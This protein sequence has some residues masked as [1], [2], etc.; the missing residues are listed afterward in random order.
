MNFEDIEMDGVESR[1]VRSTV[2]NLI[3][4]IGLIYQ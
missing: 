4:K 3:D 2:R 1:N